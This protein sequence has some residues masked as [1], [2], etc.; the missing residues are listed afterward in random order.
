MKYAD[1]IINLN[2]FREKIASCNGVEWTQIHNILDENN[3]KNDDGIITIFDVPVNAISIISQWI[4][5]ANVSDGS[6]SRY[7]LFNEF[8]DIK[9]IRY[10]K[11]SNEIKSM[12][13]IIQ[14]DYDFLRDYQSETIARFLKNNTS[15]FAYEMGLG[16]TFTSVF[17]MLIKQNT[18]FV[19]IAPL[20]VLGEFEKT[21]LMS[22]MFGFDDCKYYIPQNNNEIFEAIENNDGIILMNYEK[23]NDVIVSRLGKYIGY[24][25]V[26][27]DETSKIKN[28]KTNKYDYISKLISR[29]ENHEF[30]FIMLNGTPVENDYSDIVNQVNLLTRFVYQ[31]DLAFENEN[32]VWITALQFMIASRY[33]EL[34]TNQSTDKI[35]VVK[36][37]VDN[38]IHEIMDNYEKI[39][40]KKYNLAEDVKDYKNN[41]Q[42]IKIAKSIIQYEGIKRHKFDSI[43]FMTNYAKSAK[44]LYKELK[45][46]SDILEV[47]LVHGQM[48]N[49][50]KDETINNFKLYDGDKIA[51][52]VA[53]TVIERGVSF[54]NVD[55]LVLY[56]MPY[57]P[58]VLLQRAFRIIRDKELKNKKYIYSVL[59][60]Q[61]VK[62]LITMRDK[63]RKW[64][65]VLPVL[66]SKP[67][68]RKI[69]AL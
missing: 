69:F 49:T 19:V 13:D 54:N 21:I 35:D 15:Y 20:A 37:Y 18:K 43:V 10:G 61:D 60:N 26:I 27:V 62:R 28:E 25:G 16:K 56:E 29:T 34:E 67:F 50:N 23:L 32:Y 64:V 45:K 3:I 44:E 58:S 38:S 14:H 57:N 8:V 42:K 9:N 31:S 6:M 2:A 68:Y 65:E 4:N 33:I 7:N 40:D 47:Y 24:N 36:Y 1:V 5:S 53:T 59:N 12:V 30:S 48:S 66:Y 39:K 63:V 41:E 46:Y 17:A 55:A 51:V 52:L 11:N 22:K